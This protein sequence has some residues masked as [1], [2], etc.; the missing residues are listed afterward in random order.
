MG[1][2]APL[3]RGDGPGFVIRPNVRSED[4]EK[5]PDAAEQWKQTIAHHRYKCKKTTTQLW[6]L[7]EDL[8]AADGCMSP[9]RDAALL[10]I[11]VIIYSRFIL[12]LNSAPS[13]RCGASASCRQNRLARHRR[14]EAHHQNPPVIIVVIVVYSLFL[15]GN[16]LQVVC[17]ASVVCSLLSSS[18]DQW[19]CCSAAP[20]LLLLLAFLRQLLVSSSSPPSDSHSRSWSHYDT[21][22]ERGR[23]NRKVENTNQRRWRDDESESKYVGVD[24]FLL[25][26]WLNLFFS[27]LDHNSFSFNKGNA[28]FFH[29]LKLLIHLLGFPLLRVLMIN[30]DRLGFYLFCIQNFSSLFFS[31]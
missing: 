19:C 2:D 28:L 21:C 29:C 31:S 7:E 14:V 10:N 27:S 23:W 30:S 3:V 15:P 16:R 1:P 4:G 25:V 18:V 11:A 5:R 22:A 20:L 26:Y 6:D 13:A 12:F 9:V 17:S 8:S 24:L